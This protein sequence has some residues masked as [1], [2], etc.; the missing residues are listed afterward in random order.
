MTYKLVMH[1]TF[2]SFKADTLTSDYEEAI[3]F[4][5]DEVDSVRENQPEIYEENYEGYE[6]IL[7]GLE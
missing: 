1:M 4:A 7:E 3:R 6:L 2:G 5:K